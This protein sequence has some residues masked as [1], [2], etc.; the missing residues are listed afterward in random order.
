[1]SKDV[2]YR[3]KAQAIRNQARDH[4]HKLRMERLAR[5]QHSINSKAQ[6][7]QK[8]TQAEAMQNDISGALTRSHDDLGEAA[9]KPLDKTEFHDASPSNASDTLQEARAV[10]DISTTQTKTVTSQS[11]TPEILDNTFAKNYPKSFSPPPPA[12]SKSEFRTIARP[13]NE[14][15]HEQTA[16]TMTFCAHEMTQDMPHN[17][18]EDTAESSQDL[19]NFIQDIQDLPFD[20]AGLSAASS[21]ATI[22]TLGEGMVWR[23]KQLGIETLDDLA[24]HDIEDIK[25]SLGPIGQ[26]VRADLWISFAK[27]TCALDKTAKTQ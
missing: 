26:M 21:V 8:P 2:S 17:S 1:M 13:K 22:P 14:L 27:T 5:R 20:T 25:S 19:Q 15:A 18:K 7:S 11:K 24:K 3:E 12:S 16:Q 10:E 6:I 4:L 23:L 9:D